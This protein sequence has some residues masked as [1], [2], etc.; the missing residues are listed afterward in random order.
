MCVQENFQHS[1]MPMRPRLSATKSSDT[2]TMK[3]FKKLSGVAKK[4]AFFYP[5]RTFA[6]QCH[7]MVTDL[8][9]DAYAEGT[10]GTRIALLTELFP[11]LLSAEEAFPAL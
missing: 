11:S 5:G 10:G 2:T 4:L 1:S 3:N 8:V 6:T 9:R 7:T